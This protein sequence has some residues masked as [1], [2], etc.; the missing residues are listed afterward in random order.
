[1]LQNKTKIESTNP[2]GTWN[3]KNHQWNKF[4]CL[5]LQS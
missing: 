4:N 2:I 5:A 3:N 1:M